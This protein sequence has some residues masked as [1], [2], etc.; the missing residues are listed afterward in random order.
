MSMLNLPENRALA[1]RR[2]HVLVTALALAAL[3]TAALVPA[4]AGPDTERRPAQVMS[5]L[6]ADWLERPDRDGE[7]RPDEVIQVMGLADDDVVADIGCGTGY[8][9]RPMA[10]AVAPRG[11]VY[12][13]DIQPEMLRLL[14]ER[15]EEEGL[16]N[17]EPV[18]SESDDPKLPPGSLDW[19]LLVDV[20]HE[21]QQPRA[22]LAKMREALKPDGKIALLE[23]RLE[24]LSAVHIKEDHRMSPEQ[25][26]R[27]WEPAGY[28]LAA[29]H[30]F[31]PTQH[32]F[33]FE[34]APEG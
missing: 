7:Q 30:E 6:G 24:G 34:K 4:V 13:V 32:F 23:Y 20:Y 25:V 28:R 22:M 11:R 3:A 2:T 31:L 14:R 33:V 10:R 17:V 15:V 12:A 1:P 9:T 27:E 18:L 19:I 26:L 16:T 21:F 29:R 8:F 5:W